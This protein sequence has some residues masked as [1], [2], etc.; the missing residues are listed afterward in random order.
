M[1]NV[2]IDLHLH[3]TASDGRL[4]PA[5]LISEARR[6]GLTTIA[7]TDHD[8]TA[9][10]PEAQAAAQGN[11]V[12]IPGIE[13][14]TAD[15]GQDVHMLGYFIDVEQR[16]LQDSLRDFRDARDSRARKIVTRLSELNMPVSWEQVTQIANGG[17]IGRPH[18]A[19]AMVQAGHVG[20]VS[21]AFTKYLYTG[22]P[23][24]VARQRLTP[25]QGV[26]L[27]HSAGGV[28]VLAHPGLVNDYDSL[29]IRLVAAGLDGVE[30][31]HPKNAPDV[32]ARLWELVEQYHLIPT[33]GSDFH[34]AERGPMASEIP[35]DGCVARLEAQAQHYHQS[36]K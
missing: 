4:T 27:I 26:A 1:K 3:T 29:A 19:Q 31:N 16:E 23:A 9:G 17:A 15:N 10:I 30:V 25:E 33:G 6:L 32:R 13:L 24:Y 5:E 20:S 34:N 22:G 18:V 2:Q 7:I 35:P 8:T 14:S 11:P 21:E 28:A 12:I 36:A